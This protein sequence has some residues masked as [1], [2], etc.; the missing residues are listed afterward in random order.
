M[1]KRTVELFQRYKPEEVVMWC[2]SCMFFYDEIQKFPWPFPVRH[3]TEFLADRLPSIKF[4]DRV[5]RTVALHYH[6]QSAPRLREG[7]AGRRLLEAVP[8]LSLVDVGSEPRLGRLCT[9]DVQAQLG[10]DA[11]DALIRDEIERARAGGAETLATIYHGCQRLMCGFETEGR[12]TIEHYLSVFARGLGIEFEDTYKRWM[13][14]GDPAAIMA[15]ATPCMEANGV[16]AGAAR[17]FVDR[18]FV[19]LRPPARVAE[20]STPS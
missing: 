12:I 17:A 18:T 8:G 14:S 2:P 19:P 5:D 16:D 6:S 11:W 7:A 4:T 3:T 13:L 1:N 9:A 20:G 15:E 10:Q